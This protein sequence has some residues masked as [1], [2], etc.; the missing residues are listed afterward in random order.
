MQIGSYQV[1]L[2]DAGRYKLDGGAMF[3][4]V[5]R[6][7]W[8]KENPPDEKNRITM[9]LNTL[10]IIRDGR[11]IL[12]D[13]GVGAKFSE[14][15][16]QIYAV[17]YS[18][19]SLLKS[20][21][22]KNIQPEDVTDVII[23]HLHFD[24]VGG[25]TYYDEEGKLKLRFPNA[26]HY[27]QKRQLD[28][29]QK[30]FPKDRASYLVE[31]IDPLLH[32]NQLKILDGAHVLETGLE[33]ILSEGHTVAQQMVHVSGLQQNLLYAADMI[34]MSAHIPVPWVMAYDLYPVITIQEKEEHLKKVVEQEWMIFFEHD[35]HVHCGTIEQEDRGYQLKESIYL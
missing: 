30:R 17:D 35:P 24:H 31:N 18:E 27:I 22:T 33:L 26:D 32:S 19:H 7:L 28:W 13:T 8:E 12:V 4:V 11:I 16:Q 9:S 23:T 21:A 34:P 15:Y 3:G 2:I 20:L 29:A 6:N 14:K 10:L 1:E 5:P 25:A